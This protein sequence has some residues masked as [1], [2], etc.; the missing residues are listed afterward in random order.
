MIR[1]MR[2]FRKDMNKQLCVLRY[3]MLAVII[4]TTLLG[5]S[6]WES[7]ENFPLTFLC[8]FVVTGDI[9]EPMGINDRK[10]LNV[11]VILCQN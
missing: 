7:N 2:Q 4:Y 3:S 9:C 10:R 11:A 1:V 6:I 5:V 8:I